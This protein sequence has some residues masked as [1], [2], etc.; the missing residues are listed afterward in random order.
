[1]LAQ[2]AWPKRG[3]GTDHA[4]TQ[5]FQCSWVKQDLSVAV[6]RAFVGVAVGIVLLAPP[7]IN[8]TNEKMVGTIPRPMANSSLTNRSGSIAVAGTA[9][10]VAASR[11]AVVQSMSGGPCKTRIS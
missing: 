7:A 10:A 6:A 4:R 11:I 5:G 8:P 2:T 1:M 3:P 9:S